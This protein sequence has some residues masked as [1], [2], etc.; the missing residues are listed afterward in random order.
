MVIIPYMPPPN[1][2]FKID[3]FAIIT[4]SS[5]NV[6]EMTQHLPG[7][8]GAFKVYGLSDRP[9]PN[10]Y[11]AASQCLSLGQVAELSGALVST[12]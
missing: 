6:N 11:S 2:F 10:T 4:G 7:S 5:I 9:D 12:T 3:V 8:L 1:I